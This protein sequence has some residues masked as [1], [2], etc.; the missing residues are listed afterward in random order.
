MCQVPSYRRLLCFP[1][2]REPPITAREDEALGNESPI[3]F[4]DSLI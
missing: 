2:C 3:V 1:K 4:I